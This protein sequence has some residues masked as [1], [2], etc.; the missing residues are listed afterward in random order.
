M[1][2]FEER[3][4][5]VVAEE[6]RSIRT[7][8]KQKEH[9][10]VTKEVSNSQLQKQTLIGDGQRKKKPEEPKHSD[11]RVEI[12]RLKQSN[13]NENKT[14]NHN[15]E[16]DQQDI[17]SEK[18]IRCDRYVETAVQCGY[19]KCEGTTMQEYPE[20]M[21]YICKKDKVNQEER[22]W[23]SKYKVTVIELEELKDKYKESI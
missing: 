16:K 1:Q 22:I 11:R 23:E 21:Q 7:R 19:F 20:E 12:N 18:C 17:K 6:I 2:Y 9:N 3:I 8:A 14:E 10:D 4:E 13:Y 15:V 5:E